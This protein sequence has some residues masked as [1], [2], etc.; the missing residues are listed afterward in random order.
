MLRPDQGPAVAKFS[1]TSFACHLGDE[2]SIAVKAK[3]LKKDVCLWRKMSAVVDDT[4]DDLADARRLYRSKDSNTVTV[5]KA[6]LK[7][8]QPSSQTAWDE[9]PGDEPAPLW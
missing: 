8:R 1:A 5:L 9:A 6:S 3:Y 7:W 4:R 2:C